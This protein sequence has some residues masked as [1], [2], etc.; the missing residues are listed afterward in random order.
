MMN[1]ELLFFE[2]IIFYLSKMRQRFSASKLP[3][4]DFSKLIQNDSI[5]EKPEPII[6][7]PLLK[8]I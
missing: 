1:D 7:N 8:M 3:F 6:V 5:I 2:N 4:M